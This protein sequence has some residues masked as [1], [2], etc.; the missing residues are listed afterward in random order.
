MSSSEAQATVHANPQL[1]TLE[2]L[3][4]PQRLQV[5]SHYKLSDKRA[6]TV[7]ACSIRVLKD[8]ST[9]HKADTE[10]DVTPYSSVT[11]I[12]RR[13]RKS[14]KIQKAYD[15]VT[16]QP[17]KLSDFCALHDVSSNTIT[18]CGRFNR[19]DV[20]I[21][22]INGERMIYKTGSPFVKTET[23]AVATT[24]ATVADAS[25]TETV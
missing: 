10:F 1:T 14:T 11:S 2:H 20:K 8:M 9:E 3:T 22:T 21:S 19:T 5:I 25:S 24:T 13:G 7:F 23:P 16:D 12:Q 6:A 18:Q 17:Q 15:A 4:W